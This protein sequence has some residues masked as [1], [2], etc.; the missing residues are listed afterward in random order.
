MLQ[1][2]E[3]KNDE[4]DVDKEHGALDRYG[5][6]VRKP[7]LEPTKESQLPEA[8]AH[9]DEGEQGTVLTLAAPYTRTELVEGFAGV[10]WH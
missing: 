1:P 8:Q 10:H 7:A 4:T 2:P 9:A 5:S 3:Q 6:P